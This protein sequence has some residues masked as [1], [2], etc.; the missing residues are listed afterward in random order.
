MTSNT[1]VLFNTITESFYNILRFE[2][3]KKEKKWKKRK[4]KECKNY[5]Y[6]DQ[7]HGSNMLDTKFGTV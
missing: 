3:R 1:H 4:T 2:S 5:R 6:I 7:R